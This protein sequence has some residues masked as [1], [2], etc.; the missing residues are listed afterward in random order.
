ML[1]NTAAVIT[2]GL[3]MV[4]N[5]QESTEENIGVA[6]EMCGLQLW[7]E[8]L[9]FAQ[10]WHL[11]DPTDWNALH[12]IG[13]GFSGLK[14]FR[15]AESAYRQALSINPLAVKI[16]NNLAGILFE[17]LNCQKEGIRCMEQSLKIDSRHKVGW[18]NLA[19]MCGRLGEYENVIIYAEKAIALDAEFVEAHLLKGRAALALGK[20]DL[21]KDACQK[22]S[23]IKPEK[24]LRTT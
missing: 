6:R 11:N 7:N 1:L 9:A 16:W 8:V 23:S 14:Q 17:H 12:Y 20:M 18:S 19:T 5:I 13:I 15:K 10:Q 3:G 4:S 2:S 22:L 24:F 21:V